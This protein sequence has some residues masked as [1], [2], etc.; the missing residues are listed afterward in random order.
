MHHTWPHESFSGLTAVYNSSDE[1]TIFRI[2]HFEA[3]RW[4]RSFSVFVLSIKKVKLKNLEWFFLPCSRRNKLRS[5]IK[6]AKRKRWYKSITWY[7]EMA[8]GNFHIQYRLSTQRLVHSA[9]VFRGKIQILL[10]PAGIRRTS[11]PKKKKN[12]L[13]PFDQL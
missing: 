12:S 13:L 6:T 9:H 7:S 10:S 2:Y 4:I 8:E 1:N 3:K 5:S 11:L